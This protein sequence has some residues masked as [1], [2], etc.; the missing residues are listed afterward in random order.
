M[1]AEEE[2]DDEREGK[3]R[4]VVRRG[5]EGYEV[6]PVGREEMLKRYLEELGEEPGR[7]LQ[8][9]PE[10]DSDSEEEFEGKDNEVDSEN[11]PLAQA[12]R[13]RSRGQE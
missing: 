9:I 2:S 6:R 13:G 3:R 4:T 11:V 12:L 1:F 5:S 7:Y 10:P 8:Y